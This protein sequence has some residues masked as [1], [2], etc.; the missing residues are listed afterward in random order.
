MKTIWITILGW[1]FLF[2]GIIGFF[3]PMLQGILFTFIGLILLS[4][5]SP[6]AERF[7]LK[8]RERYPKL[9]RTSDLWLAHFLSRFRLKSSSSH[10]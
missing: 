4:K 10:E 9:A 3:A 1:T 2:L 6:W 8:M 7:L 5:T